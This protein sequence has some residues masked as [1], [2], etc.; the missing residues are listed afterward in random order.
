MDQLPLL[1]AATPSALSYKCSV[2]F[3]CTAGMPEEAR[4]SYLQVVHKGGDDDVFVTIAE[5]VMDDG[6]CI[7]AGADFSHPLQCNVCPALTLRR[8]LILRMPACKVPHGPACW[9]NIRSRTHRG[10]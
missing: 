2:H 1:L 8:S 3:Q 4:A 5:E 7:D 6:R 10:Y 9:R